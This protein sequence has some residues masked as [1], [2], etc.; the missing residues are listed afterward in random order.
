NET[1]EERYQIFKPYWDFVQPNG[2]KSAAAA[3]SFLIASLEYLKESGREFQFNDVTLKHYFSEDELTETQVSLLKALYR[4]NY[5]FA[6]DET[7]QKL[8]EKDYKSIRYKQAK[9]DMKKIGISINNQKWIDGVNTKV[10]KVGN[11]EL[12]NMGLELISKD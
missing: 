5:I 11:P 1:D 4:Q 8:I 3:V 7:L 10:H 12:F 9:D 6:G 2:K